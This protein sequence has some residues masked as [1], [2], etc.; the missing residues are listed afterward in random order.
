MIYS[1]DQIR[2]VHLELTDRCNAAC[3]MCPRYDQNTG[4]VAGVVT[5]AQLHLEDIFQIMS[6]SFIQQINRVNFCG[7]YGDPI[8]ARD[9]LPIIEY[10]LRYNP[11]MRVE[12]NTNG[13][14]R[15]VE[16]W[17]HLALLLG[18]DEAQGGVWFGLDG[19][20][21]TNHLYRRNTNWD[22]IMRNARAFIAK[23]GVAH[24]NF[25]A[26]KHNEHQ[27]DEARALAKEMGFKHFNVKLTG[28]FKETQ[29]FPVMVKGEHLYDL[30]PAEAERH[31]RP[32]LPSKVPEVDWSNRMEEIKASLARQGYLNGRTQIPVETKS[33]V[34]ECIAAQEKCI[35]VSAQGKIYPCCWL[36]D[37][38]NVDPQ[39]NFTNNSHASTPTKVIVEGPDFQA[40]EDSWETGSI[41]K[42]VRF[43]GVNETEDKLKHGPDYVVHEKL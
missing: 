27:I 14:A 26:F 22:I 13:S 20:A 2:A 24:W 32:V 21:D 23:G 30:E 4:D 17:E 9:L 12:V 1:Y 43:C 18:P 29:A 36:G 15:P 11:Q 40:V 19:L 28:R 33:P 37:A 8:V 35:Y 7:N 42:C 5:G 38:D 6:A 34:I 10:F 31:Q 16:W 3:P 39:V 25:I 41:H